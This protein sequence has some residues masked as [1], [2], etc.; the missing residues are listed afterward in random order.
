VA[1]R[2]S[3]FGFKVGQGRVKFWVQGLGIR[4]SGDLGSG[5]EV[6]QGRVTSRVEGLEFRVSGV[7][8]GRVG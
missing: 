7:R 2:V 4:Y 5:F 8:K 1:F 6:G 3:G